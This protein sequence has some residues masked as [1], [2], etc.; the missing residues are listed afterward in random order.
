MSHLKPTDDLRQSIRE[1]MS[2]LFDDFKCSIIREFDIKTSEILNRLTKV[3]ETIYNLESKYEKLKVDFEDSVK[4][5]NQLKTENQDLK[6]T[7]MSLTDRV[8]QLEQHS[9]AANVEIQCI[10]EFNRENLI[11]TVKQIA[12]TIKYNL[13]E[14]DIHLCTRISKINKENKRPRS[15]VVKFSCPRV[16]DGFLAAAVIFNKKATTN[17]DKLNTSHLGIGGER[18]PVYIG[19]HLSP[20]MKSLHAAARARAKELHYRFVWVKSGKIFLRKTET[21]EYILINSAT[22]LAELK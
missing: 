22:S 3:D 2:A 6:S 10:P 14:N 1:E 12:S 5:V 18:R 20:A 8:S 21:S 7:V 17:E 9:R 11:T 4:T 16:R 13:C 19:E 15:V